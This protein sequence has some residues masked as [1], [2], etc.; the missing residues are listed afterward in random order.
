M[1]K[2]SE[3]LSDNFPGRWFPLTIP[4]CITYVGLKNLTV[5]GESKDLATVHL[6]CGNEE[7]VV[8]VWIDQVID[9]IFERTHPL[10]GK[11][12]PCCLLHNVV[13][14]TSDSSDFVAS[15]ALDSGSSNSFR[16]RQPVAVTWL[17]S[18]EAELHFPFL[19]P[20][21]LV[22]FADSEVVGESPFPD[23]F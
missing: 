12:A 19:G 3:V 2:P 23:T 21:P 4:G 7:F 9:E 15:E 8:E 18:E 20:A 10:L 13:I 16:S 6:V 1:V 11:P 5:R 14:S 17:D 22:Q